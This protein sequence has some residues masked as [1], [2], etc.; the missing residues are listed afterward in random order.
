MGL[1][2][3]LAKPDSVD[4]MKH[5]D[6]QVARAVAPFRENTE[7]MI[8]IFS[9]VRVARKLLDL[10]PPHTRLEIIQQVIVPHLEGE[11]AEEGLIIQ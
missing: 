4:R 7:A 8:V 6:T 3:V 11:H 9:L 2:E 10:Y 1:S 5:I